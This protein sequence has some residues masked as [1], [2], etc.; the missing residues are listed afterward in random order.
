M[1]EIW[2]EC[3]SFN[4][5]SQRLADQTRTI[6]KK[7]CSSDLEIL[8]IYQQINREEYQQNY[9]MLAEMLNTEKQELPNQTE[10]QNN[11]NWNITHPNTTKQML[12]QEDNK[13]RVIK[14]NHD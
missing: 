11:G 12:T 3:A 4:R 7:D 13:C 9:T 14:E 6:L 10:M 1:V 2:L 5:T 8:E